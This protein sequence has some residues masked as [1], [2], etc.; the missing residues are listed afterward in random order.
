MKQDESFHKI[1]FDG[2]KFLKVKRGHIAETLETL[3]VRYAEDN[4]LPTLGIFLTERL[5]P[6]EIFQCWMHY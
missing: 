1:D 4:T 5:S 2:K 6:Q 3:F